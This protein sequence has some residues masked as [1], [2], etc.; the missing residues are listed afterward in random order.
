M[1]SI[2][3]GFWKNCINSTVSDVSSTILKGIFKAVGQ[4][5]DNS[6]TSTNKNH[7]SKPSNIVKNKWF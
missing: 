5:V 4:N 3:L 7:E 6:R 1:V 2:N